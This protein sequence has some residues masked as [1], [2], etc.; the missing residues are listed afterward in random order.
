[1]RVIT[2]EDVE[3]ERLAEGRALGELFLDQLCRRLPFLRHMMGRGDEHPNELRRRFAHVTR[4]RSISSLRDPS[5]AVNTRCTVTY[6]TG[7]AMALCS[8]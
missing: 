6:T 5:R 3:F 4:R 1:M 7:E 2:S 8:I